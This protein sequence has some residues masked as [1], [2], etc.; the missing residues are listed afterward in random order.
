MRVLIA[1]LGEHKEFGLRSLRD[2]GHWVGVLE[3]PGRAP[4]DHVDWWAPAAYRD[5]DSVVAAARRGGPWDALVCWEE[6]AIDV[7]HEAARRLALPGPRMPAGRF[8]DKAVMAERIRQAGLPSPRL[9]TAQSLERARELAGGHDTLV[10]KPADYGGSGGVR[11]VRGPADFD[12]AVRVAL[13]LSFSGRTVIDRFLPG[14]EYSVESVTWAP[15]DTQVLAV[16]E[17]RTTPPPFCA[18]TG[19]RVPA[20]LPDADRDRLAAEAV[21]MLDT[22]GME[23]GVSH[24]EF[25]LTPGGPVLL[26]VAGR[27]AGDQIP[28]LVDLVTG[29]NIY[30]AEVAAVAGTRPRP[31]A[32]AAEAAAVHFFTGDGGP[33]AYRPIDVAE[34]SAPPLRDT[35]FELRF[36]LAPDAPLRPPQDVDD[37]AGYAILAGTATDVDAAGA[38]LATRQRQ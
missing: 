38:A 15:G 16:V 10:V 17:N 23:C 12:D 29:W 28:R 20:R 8:R 22:L 31:A 24:S 3:E 4:R 13:E 21:R 18:E 34:A 32:P 26:E 35:L 37:R 33:V 25:K 5:V 9:G 36:W 27:P 7:A 19:Q 1:G 6:V 2:A 11:I 14:P 30:V